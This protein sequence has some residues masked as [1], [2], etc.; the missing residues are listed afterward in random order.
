MK[1]KKISFENREGMQ[2]AAWMQFPTDRHPHSYAVFAHCFTCGKDLGTIYNIA[3]SLCDHG[4]AVMRFDFTGIGE[5]EGDFA[6]TNFSSNVDDLIAAAEY[7]ESNYEAPR[8]L[9]GHSLGGSAVLVAGGRIS[10][11]S[12]V[13][14]IAAP[15]SPTHVKRLISSDIEKIAEDGKATVNIAGRE[16]T[17][18]E[19]F[20]KD[21]AS[22]ES[23]EAIRN[24]DAALL[25]MHSPDDKIVEIDNAT[26]IFK[27]AQ[28]NKSYVSLDGADHL[29]KRKRDSLY[30]GNVIGAWASRYV[31]LPEPWKLESDHAVVCQT[32]TDRYTTKVQVGKHRLIG[33]EPTS[34]GGND[35]GP[36]P[37]Q[38]L[39]A[40]LG[41]CT[42]MTIRMYADRKEWPVEKITV[43]LDHNKIHAK[44]CEDCESE[45]GRIDHITRIIEVEG[46]LDEEQRGRLLEIA[47]KCPVHKTLHGE[48]KVRSEVRED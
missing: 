14:T 10:S 13:A 27:A 16:F 8:L 38:Y 28:E 40:A 5:S 31:D 19:Q 21:V 20:L 47:D 39:S 34:Y 35:F 11:V 24:L 1:I 18:K 37:Y 12:A 15:Y 30:A 32:G 26:K 6:D 48:I 23:N 7:L 3:A 29:I 33:D 25:V 2:L 9:L 43:H 4:F 41:T 22:I 36:S 45:E 46:D 44:D 42:A 17:I